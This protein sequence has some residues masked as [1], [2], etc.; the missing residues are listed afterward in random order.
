MSTPAKIE[1]ATDT[2]TPAPDDADPPP[3]DFIQLPDSYHNDTETLDVQRLDYHVKTADV[4]HEFDVA[5]KALSAKVSDKWATRNLPYLRV[6]VLLL[7]W[8]EDDLGVEEE[9]SELQDLLTRFFR[10]AVEPWVIPKGKPKRVY[11]ALMK[12][13]HDFTEAH[14]TQDA[15]LWI[16]YGGHA[17]QD[18]RYPGR[19]PVWF[20]KRST[21]TDGDTHVQ[22]ALLLP[23]LSDLDCD[24]LLLFDSCQAIPPNIT[25]TGQGVVSVLSATGFEGGVAGIAPGVGPH[26]FTRG[27][28]DELASLLNH[29]VNSAD[30]QP[31]SDIA[32]HG[33]LLARLKIHLSTVD[34]D[35]RGKIKCAQNGSVVFEPVQRRTPFY[36]FLSDNKKPRPIYIA[37]LPARPT[38]YIPGEVP[39]PFLTLV[40][41]PSSAPDTKVETPNVLIRILLREGSFNT[42]DFAAW[43]LQA[44]KDAVNIEIEGVY[45]SLST[46]LIV[47]M[48]LSVW[49]LLP[50]DPA[51]SLVGYVTTDNQADDINEELRN[52]TRGGLTNIRTRQKTTSASPAREGSAG[53]STNEQDFAYKGPFR[54]GFQ[55]RQD[56]SLADSTMGDITVDSSASH[57][58]TPGPVYPDDWQNPPPPTARPHYTPVRG[59]HHR[60][61]GCR[62]EA[63]RYRERFAKGKFYVWFCCACS[64]GPY[65][66]E[67]IPACQNFNCSGS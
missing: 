55:M 53:P 65:S 61:S 22:S 11:M 39:C 43:L 18:P 62:I 5:I 54:P 40:S 20:P 25:S 10:Y 24:V 32:L 45:G 44:P 46:L 13:L 30:A 64:D 52:M 56:T 41:P 3:F 23:I 36:R 28:I 66:I 38:Q 16:Y 48:P 17:R 59:A 14:N 4:I 60:C 51:L 50:R 12:K 47:K 63:H 19:G 26:S 27:L 67:N 34:K 21:G 31:T 57:T 37:P 2:V 58:Q 9:I 33:N 15:L 29:F 42:A 7:H 8:E 6:A 1:E 49:N 35:P